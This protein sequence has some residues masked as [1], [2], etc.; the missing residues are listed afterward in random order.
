[1]AIL[2][3]FNEKLQETFANVYDITG[4]LSIEPF[5]QGSVFRLSFPNSEAVH[6][7][8]FYFLDDT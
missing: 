7:K 5:Y 2:G 3:T 6:G 1:M 4:Y 8:S